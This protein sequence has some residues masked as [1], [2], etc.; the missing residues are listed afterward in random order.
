[1]DGRVGNRSASRV[2]QLREVA[3]LLLA[4]A[5]RRPSRYRPPAESRGRL[6]RLARQRPALRLA[7]RSPR[8]AAGAMFRAPPRDAAHRPRRRE[9]GAGAGRGGEDRIGCLGGAP[10]H[11]MRATRVPGALPDREGGTCEDRRRRHFGRGSIPRVLPASRA[12]PRPPAESGTQTDRL[13]HPSLEPACPRPPPTPARAGISD[14]RPAARA[15]ELPRRRQARERQR[16][17][18]P[19]DLPRTPVL[20]E[21]VREV[22]AHR[23]VSAPRQAPLRQPRLPALRGAR[24]RRPRRRQGALAGHPRLSARPHRAG[25]HR[26]RHAAQAAQRARHAQ[27]RLGPARARDQCASNRKAIPCGGASRS[28]DSARVAPRPSVAPCAMARRAPVR[29]RRTPPSV[30]ESPAQGVTTPGAPGRPRP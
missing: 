22:H 6:R 5:P 12:R 9:S 14:E 16:A 26:Y 27:L 8:R 15:P 30:R 11:R 28:S 21:P 1:M 25:P 10:V 24:H 2:S 3:A 4:R 23:A 20:G 17:L 18:H 7:T 19:L 13:A 29:S